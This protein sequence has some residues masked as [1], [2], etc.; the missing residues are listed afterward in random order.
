MK[1]GASI[2]IS[3]VLPHGGCPHGMN[4][5]NREVAGSDIPE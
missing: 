3:Y 1:F 5:L 4:W 2:H